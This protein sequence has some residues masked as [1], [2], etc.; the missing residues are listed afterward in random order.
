MDDDDFRV[1][2]DRAARRHRQRHGY[3]RR[4][5]LEF[6]DELVEIIAALLNEQPW[7]TTRRLVVGVQIENNQKV[8]LHLAEQDQAGA[9]LPVDQGVISW[10]A[11]RSDLVTLQPSDDGT[12]CEV[13]AVDAATEGDTQVTASVQLPDAGDGLGMPAP[14][15]AP[16]FVVT[17]AAAGAPVAAVI[18]A[19]APEQ[20]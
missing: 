12:T 8:L 3:V 9:Y 6:I 14:I 2:L 13:V 17:M 1:H 10:S 7:P 5:L 4:E 20:K 18:T 15:L 11:D 19:D 16:P